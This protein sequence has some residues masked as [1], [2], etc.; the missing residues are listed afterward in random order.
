MK[1]IFR[2]IVM[3]L[4]VAFAVISCDL[5][6]A[7][8]SARKEP[9]MEAGKGRITIVL[10]G[11]AIAPPAAAGRAASRAVA[12]AGDPTIPLYYKLTFTHAT[13]GSY[14]LT[15]GAVSEK[16]LTL[17]E[18]SWTINATA[19]DDN[20]YTN[21]VGNGAKA[22]AIA[23]DVPVTETISMILDSNYEAGLSTYFIHNE[24]ELRRIGPG[25]LS[26]TSGKTYHLVNDITLTDPWTPLGDD[27]TSFGATFD[28][29]GKKITIQSFAPTALM[30]QYLGLF[31]NATQATI[32]D[33]TVE[34]AANAFG[35]QDSP[36]ELTFSPTR[37]GGLA[38]ALGNTT[39]TGITVSVLGD[40]GI[41]AT[42]NILGA[43]LE[44]GG[45]TGRLNG[46]GSHPFA[47]NTFTGNIG[48]GDIGTGDIGASA[49]EVLV[50]GI[51]GYSNIAITNSH[52]VGTITV[53]G[54]STD[55][56]STLFGGSTGA[57]A[58]A[59]GIVGGNYGN[60]EKSSFTGGVKISA[61]I[62]G[63]A[64]GIV[65][66]SAS[67]NVRSSYAAANGA[68][69]RTITA[70][71]SNTSSGIA[72]AGGIAGIA[73][74][75]GYKIENSYAY[76]DVKADGRVKGI[77]GGIAGELGS[78][79]EITNTYALGTVEAVGTPAAVTGNAYAGG[80]VGNTSNSNKVN[81]SI[82]LNST[83]KGNGNPVVHGIG[84]SVTTDT[85]NFAAA[86]II[87]TPAVTS[88][89]NL[90]G[91]T[92]YSTDG[93]YNNVTLFREDFQRETNKA[94]YISAMPIS[95][96]VP[97]TVGLNWNFT[98]GVNDYWKYLGTDYPYP[99]LSWETVPHT[100]TG[101][102][103]TG[104]YGMSFGW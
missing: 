77:A 44:I 50:G 72:Y 28:G 24:E 88:V 49:P 18:G 5:P 27:T 45:I 6:A 2:F 16:S 51:A 76:A 60:I 9:P 22:V 100:A 37:V 71:A 83:I 23:H 94:I 13:I 10:S 39:A 56:T 89:V 79:Q 41:Y 63:Y 78:S 87:F 57:V 34:Y 52:A 33:L 85:F 98:V 25:D 26:I 65:G 7:P 1:K 3:T 99:V 29:G 36:L 40:G 103:P 92:A 74:G 59:G 55:T 48:T 19:Y 12:W 70:T 35:T 47:G 54:T 80:I 68:T 38:G 97:I 75:T 82:A 4:M 69:D 53:K 64:G 61:V 66:Y 91:Y 43:S 58:I 8:D 93:N 15:L 31:G 11:T 20:A 86:N 104:T 84:D 73:T 32:T 21:L 95:S 102:L 30:G 67:G 101:G 62:S 14:T 46:D 90:D 96:A 81:N 17:E 42:N